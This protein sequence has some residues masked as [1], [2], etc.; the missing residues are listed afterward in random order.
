MYK[1]IEFF[2]CFFVCENLSPEDASV[3]ISVIDKSFTANLISDTMDQFEV[4]IYNGTRTTVAVIH[5][6]S[7]S[8][9]DSG[10]NRFPGPD[11]STQ[12]YK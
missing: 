2:E 11:T 12:S 5:F 6:V 4:I 8:I 3:E 9:E 7:E 10:Y 1:C